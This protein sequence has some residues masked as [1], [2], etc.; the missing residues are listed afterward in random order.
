VLIKGGLLNGDDQQG[1]Y[2]LSFKGQANTGSNSGAGAPQNQI[3]FSEKILPT[4]IIVMMYRVG[5]PKPTMS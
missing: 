3:F 1:T 4:S 2:D 5:L